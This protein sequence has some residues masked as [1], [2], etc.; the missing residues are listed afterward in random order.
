MI[1]VAQNFFFWFSLL[2]PCKNV[3]HHEKR[4]C[5]K[6][7]WNRTR[8][9]G[10]TRTFNFHGF[11]A[12]LKNKCIFGIEQFIALL[13]TSDFKTNHHIIKH[14]DKQQ[15]A[16]SYWQTDMQLKSFV[17]RKTW[18]DWA[19]F[20]SRSYCLILVNLYNNTFTTV[21]QFFL[22]LANYL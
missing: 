11:D 4:H 7:F 6:Y 10:G 22:V 16:K 14:I 12:Y 20:S 8:F 17:I 2:P 1:R 15:S 5:A 19:N 9:S 3:M 18:K 21:W 13:N